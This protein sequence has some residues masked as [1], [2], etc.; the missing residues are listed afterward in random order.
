MSEISENIVKYALLYSKKY[1]IFPNWDTESGDLDW[2]YKKIE[3]KCFSSLGPSSFGPT[4]KWD[5]LYFLDAMD[6]K[7]KNFKLYEIRM[8]N[9]HDTWCNI[10]MNK[11]ETYKEQCDSGKRP[12]I[13]FE[14]IKEQLDKIN[15]NYC[16]LIWSGHIS[17]L[18]NVG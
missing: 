7:N 8:S 15:V 16:K 11:Q 1:K 2:I 5:L 14:K 9:N 13:A 10:K 17:E 12:H 4:E 18:D 3:V 6:F